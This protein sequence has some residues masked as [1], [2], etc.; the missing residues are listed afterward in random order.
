MRRAIKSPYYQRKNIMSD[1]AKTINVTI[2]ERMAALKLF[3]AFKG[4]LATLS[5]LLEDV[6]QF[7]VT[8]AEWKE[9]NLIKTPSP[10]GETEQWKWDDTIMK[11][12]VLQPD[13]VKYLV[14][15]IKK[16]SD[17]G[18]MT[19]ADISLIALEKKLV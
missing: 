16:K 9:A 11:D 7:T 13:T 10:N 15:E 8:E 18:E 1:E 4:S 6:K 2:G 5:T 3:D 17:A 12:V 14:E 19:L